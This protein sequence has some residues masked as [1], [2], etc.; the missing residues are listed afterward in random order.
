[1]LKERNKASAYPKLPFPL[2]VITPLIKLFVNFPKFSALVLFISGTSII[3]LP[4]FETTETFRK[5]SIGIELVLIGIYIA[6]L[7]LSLLLKSKIANADQENL[8]AEEQ[9][10]EEEFIKTGINS[11]D[12]LITSFKKRLLNFSEAIST[13]GEEA[14]SLIERHETLTENLAASVVIRDAQG[15]ITYCSPYTEV[16]T[17]SPLLN[18]YES[19]EDFFII[20]AHEED[21][22]KFK[23]AFSLSTLGEAFQF[24]YRFYHKS[25]IE[26]WAEVRT[27][28]ILSE[29]SEV[30]GTLSITL[31]VTGTVRYQEQVEE[32]NK[33]LQDFSYMIS[34]DLKAPIFTIKGM[35]NVLKEDHKDK[36]NAE[37]FEILDHIDGAAQR[38]S[39]LVKAVLEYSK[40]T[41]RNNINEAVIISEILKEVISDHSSTIQECKACITLPLVLPTVIGDRTMVYQIFSNLIGNALKYKQTGKAVKI[42]IESIPGK[43]MAYASILI[44]DYGLGI[45]KDKLEDIF[46]P[47]QRLHK[48]L[49][50]GSG[51]GLACVKK[52][53]LKLAG[54][55]KV[56][57]TEGQGSEFIVTLPVVR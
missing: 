19:K 38:L 40:V 17:G 45:P 49:A 3:Y 53:V 52:L 54:E 57:S 32:K 27:V 41:S 5:V 44:R 7:Y 34:H 51:I 33:D 30:L 56:N 35:V 39:S 1:M 24:K 4:L 26:M 12:S 11:L 9:D 15:K 23:R 36:F 16:L 14:E 31:D 50:D 20:S 42:E 25:G 55:I 6:A 8:F 28:P 2:W 21:R 29:E 10:L 46:R 43:N 22:D 48:E 18:I 13:I 47:F 37:T